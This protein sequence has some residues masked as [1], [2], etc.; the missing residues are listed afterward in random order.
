MR[1]ASWGGPVPFPAG[2]PADRI[3]HAPM[4]S[5]CVGNVLRL[6]TRCAQCSRVTRR[7]RSRINIRFSR[8]LP[9][10]GAFRFGSTA[11]T[12]TVAPIARSPPSM[13]RR[14]EALAA[15]DHSILTG[16]RRAARPSPP[17]AR[18]DADGPQPPTLGRSAAHRRL[19][20]VSR[21]SAEARCS[22]AP[23]ARTHRSAP[24]RRSRHRDV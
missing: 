4:L 17:R 19:S 1:I 15:Y 23:V 10:H 3:R 5:R 14:A 21:S 6:A 20:A 24:S 9:Q 22:S 13:Y 7:I 12:L 8:E 18:A 11:K 16:Q 2:V